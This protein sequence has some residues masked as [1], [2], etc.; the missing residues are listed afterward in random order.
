M[1]LVIFPR[2]RQA[3]AMNAADEVRALTFDVFGTVVDWRSA[4]TR[5][6][7]AVGAAKG[8]EGDWGAFAA[9]WRSMYDPAMEEVRAGRRPWT[10]LDVLH[11]ESLEVLLP[12]YGLDGLD[13]AERQHLNTAWHRLDPWPDVLPGFERLKERYPLVTLSNGNVALMLNMARRAGI[14]WDTILGAE[15]SKVYKPQAEAYLITADLLGLPPEQVMLV[16][17]HPRDLDA[18]TKTGFRTAY[19]H[20]PYEYPERPPNVVPEGRYDFAAADM[21]ELAT[22]MGC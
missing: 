13:E 19:I 12:K 1:P 6:V 15:V 16:A 21:V 22:K 7:A 14:P 17:A 3:L 20:R 18:A 4:V 5:E 9:E 10:K 2:L 8:V 11:R